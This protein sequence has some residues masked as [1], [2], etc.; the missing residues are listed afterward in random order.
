MRCGA[1]SAYNPKFDWPGAFS[2]TVA[3]ENQSLATP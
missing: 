2:L 1:G 3:P